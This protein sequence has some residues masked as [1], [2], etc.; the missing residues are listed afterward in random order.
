M[1]MLKKRF[2]VEYPE[3][4]IYLV[5]L[6]THG[7]RQFVGSSLHT[8]TKAGPLSYRGMIH[9][10]V[11]NDGVPSLEHMHYTIGSTSSNDRD[12]GAFPFYLGGADDFENKLPRLLTIQKFVREFGPVMVELGLLAP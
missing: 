6:T 3:M 2:E 7:Y 10:G 8:V 1:L 4:K 5:G 11:L 12:L 9:A